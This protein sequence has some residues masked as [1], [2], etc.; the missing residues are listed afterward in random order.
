MV[1]F[2]IIIKKKKKKSLDLARLHFFQGLKVYGKPNRFHDDI[3]IYFF[4]FS[5]STVPF[6]FCLF[7]FEVKITIMNISD[8]VIIYS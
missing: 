3:F 2:L 7:T 8:Y 4:I 1:A 6:F 5:C